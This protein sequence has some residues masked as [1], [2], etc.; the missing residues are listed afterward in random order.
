MSGSLWASLPFGVALFTVNAVVEET[1]F[2]GLF[3]PTIARVTGAGSDI[4]LQ[5][6]FF[7]LHHWG[8]SAAAIQ[9]AVMFLPLTLLGAV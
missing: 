5:A 7:S 9:G 2:R 3:L 8:S 1:L 4:W 6:V